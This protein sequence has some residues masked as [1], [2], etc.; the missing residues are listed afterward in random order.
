MLSCTRP[1]GI[2]FLELSAASIPPEPLDNAICIYGSHCNAVLQ[3]RGVSSLSRHGKQ[4]RLSATASYLDRKEV[5]AMIEKLK[6]I[7]GT[8]GD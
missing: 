4:R 8:L 1:Y 5:A 2:D 6:E 3:L 7:L